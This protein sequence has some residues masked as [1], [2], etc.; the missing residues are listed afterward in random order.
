MP[1][2]KLDELPPA[3]RQPPQ[4]CSEQ[5]FGGLQQRAA[6]KDIALLRTPTRLALAPVHEGKA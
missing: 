6:A 5:A 4:Q 3:A 1:Y 2:A